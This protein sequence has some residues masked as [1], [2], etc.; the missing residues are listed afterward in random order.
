M[1]TLLK[2]S[3]LIAAAAVAGLTMAR[4]NHY[5]GLWTVLLWIVCAIGVLLLA[6]DM[7][8]RRES[9]NRQN[10]LFMVV[11]IAITILLYLIQFNQA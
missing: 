3:P 8:R 7:Y 5:T 6:L 2:V 4:H 10:L 11:S 9:L 1:K